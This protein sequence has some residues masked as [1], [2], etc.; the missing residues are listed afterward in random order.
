MA[1][2]FGEAARKVAGTRLETLSHAAR[3]V[4]V[5]VV[6]DKLGDTVVDL[7]EDLLEAVNATVDEQLVRRVTQACDPDAIEVFKGFA[8]EAAELLEHQ[9][10]LTL[11]TAEKMH[12][13]DFAQLLDLSADPSAA[14]IR[15][16]FATRDDH[17]V[18]QVRELRVAGAHVVEIEP[19]GDA[20]VH[21][22]LAS[23]SIVGQTADDIVRTA[24]GYPLFVVA[25]IE[26]VQK[27][28]SVGNLRGHDGFVAQMEMNFHA[29][30]QTEQRACVA[31]AGFTDPPDV[32]TITTL[33]G[34]TP[35]DWLV[36]EARLAE[37][38]VFPTAVDGRLWFHELGRR[39]IWGRG[40]VAGAA[41]VFGR[42]G[43]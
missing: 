7:A 13:D 25:A 36:I 15:L 14:V 37:R 35:D 24:L 2:L 23:E 18:R 28:R 31:L 3:Q 8:R 40:D 16:A 1:R 11:D 19:L 43:D 39:A 42:G 22:W 33:L 5:G 30:N 32:G 10:V 26:H 20:T 6:R 41:R 29:L 38:K 21:K 12:E 27:G 9:V 34:C 17:A 4:M